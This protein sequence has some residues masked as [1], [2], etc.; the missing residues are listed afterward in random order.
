MLVGQHGNFVRSA[1]V[2]TINFQ[3][4]NK[5]WAAKKFNKVAI[6]NSQAAGYNLERVH[7]YLRELREETST[8]LLDFYKNQQNIM[9]LIAA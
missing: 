2:A 1:A 9:G 8:E 7:D 5:D 3:I 6:I 4:A